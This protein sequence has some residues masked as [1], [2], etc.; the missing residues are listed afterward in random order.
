MKYKV[1][2]LTASNNKYLLM[3]KQLKGKFL[4]VIKFKIIKVNKIS[5]HI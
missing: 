2:K 4:T 3:R 5:T 1:K